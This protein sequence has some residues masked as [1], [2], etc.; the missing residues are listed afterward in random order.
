MHPR[1]A[2]Q[3]TPG[4][5]PSHGAITMPEKHKTRPRKARV[6]SRDSARVNADPQLRTER[7]ARG[8]ALVRDPN[9]PP[10]S[11]I[12]SVARLLARKWSQTPHS[13]AS[14]QTQSS[15]RHP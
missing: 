6:A 13:A 14:D 15:K 11:V 5:A 7:I 9:Y 10:P 3:G 1:S 4:T 12:R 8:A 2:G